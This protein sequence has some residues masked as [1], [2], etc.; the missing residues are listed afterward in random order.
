MTISLRAS[1]GSRKRARMSLSWQPVNLMDCSNGQ[2]AA[3]PSGSCTRPECHSSL[4]DT[5]TEWARATFCRVGHS[6]RRKMRRV[7]MAK[8]CLYCGLRFSETTQFCPECGRPTESGF[9]VRPV[10]GSK[11]G[12]QV[13]PR[14]AGT[15]KLEVNPHRW[16]KS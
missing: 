14:N 9:A 1:V 6:L 7:P 13:A 4:C 15:P 12:Q 16:L 2:Q 5:K 3:S 10:Q 8:Y 11:I